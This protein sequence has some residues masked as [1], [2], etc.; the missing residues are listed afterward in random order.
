[1]LS[2]TEIKIKSPTLEIP[3]RT[4]PVKIPARK[5]RSQSTSNPNETPSFAVRTHMQSGNYFKC[6]DECQRQYGDTTFCLGYC[7]FD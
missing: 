7:I 2:R 4:E 1:M 5:Q 3:R 6:M